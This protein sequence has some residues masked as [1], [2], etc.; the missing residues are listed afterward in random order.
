[1]TV[2]VSLR[3]EQKLEKGNCKVTPTIVSLTLAPLRVFFPHDSD[4]EIRELDWQ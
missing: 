1:M 3:G 4:L 2:E